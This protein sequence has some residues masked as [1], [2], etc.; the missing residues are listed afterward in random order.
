MDGVVSNKILNVTSL[1]RKLKSLSVLSKTWSL[2][3]NER[4]FTNLSESYLCTT[5]ILTLPCPLLLSLF[6][7]LLTLH[8][9]MNRKGKGVFTLCHST[10]MELLHHVQ[11]SYRTEGRY[12]IRASPSVNPHLVVTQRWNMLQK[13]ELCI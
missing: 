4:L 9:T 10:G 12:H 11:L 8:L 2:I 3:L 13:N 5:G 6:R 1:I 7:V